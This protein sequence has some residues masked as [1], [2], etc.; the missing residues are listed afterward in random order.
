M[1]SKN[2]P[3]EH[4]DLIQPWPLKHMV[5]QGY[6]PH[7]KEAACLWQF[8]IMATQALD[9]VEKQVTLEGDQDQVVD[10]RNLADSAFK[11]YDFHKLNDPYDTVFNPALVRVAQMEARSKKLPWD[12][13]LDAWF[14][15]G[16][17]SYNVMDRDADKTGL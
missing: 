16:G 3:L 6:L 4:L 17:R 8:L 10:L 7:T 2:I 15:S 5:P 9:R 11:L 1:V 13:R 14:A 12:D